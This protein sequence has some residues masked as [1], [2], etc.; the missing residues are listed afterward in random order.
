[1][2]KVTKNPIPQ[3]KYISAV[4]HANIIYTSGMTPRKDG[5][6][7]HSGKIKVSVPIEVYKEGVELATLNAIGSVLNC[8]EM[9]EKI[10]TVLQMHVF[11]N[12]EHGFTQ[13]SKIADFASETIINV[14]G[15]KSIGSRVAVGVASLPSNATVEIVLVCC[16]N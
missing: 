1:M 4:R 10:S 8:L 16:V 2:K 11:L 9:N 13:H 7:L 12:T 3:G 14:L 6:L 15:I 5:V